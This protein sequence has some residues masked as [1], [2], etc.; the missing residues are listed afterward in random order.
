MMWESKQPD[1]LWRQYFDIMPA[2]FDSLMF[3]T[4]EDLAEL[5]GS[6]IVGMSR[7]Y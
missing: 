7:T 5:T 1:S 6:T 2:S 3:W 4:D